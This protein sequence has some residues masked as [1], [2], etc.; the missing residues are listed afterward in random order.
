MIDQQQRQDGEHEVDQTESD[1]PQQRGHF[2]EAGGGEDLR[3]DLIARLELGDPR[4]RLG[5]DAKTDP[6][7]RRAAFSTDDQGET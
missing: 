3:A 4:E 7:K 6:P 1:L 5:D 2:A